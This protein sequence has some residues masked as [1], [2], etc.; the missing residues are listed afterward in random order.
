MTHEDLIAHLAQQLGWSNDTVSASLDALIA[1]LKSELDDNK[2]VTIDDFGRFLVRNYP[3]YILRD[4]ETNE[5]YLMPPALEVEFEGEVSLCFTPDDALNDSVN[6]AFSPFEPVLINEGADFPGLQEVVDQELDAN[7]QE[8][9]DADIAPQQ[10]VAEV[11]DTNMHEV[12]DEDVAPQHAVAEEMEETLQVEKAEQVVMVKDR[13]DLP[14]LRKKKKGKKSSSVW[15]PIAGGVAVALAVLFFFKGGEP[16]KSEVSGQSPSVPITEKVSMESPVAEEP[17]DVVLP[18]T[19]INAPSQEATK[20]RL[21]QGKT[22]R[23]LALELFGSR[24]FW[25]YIYLENKTQISNP[26][27]VPIGLELIV[28]DQ[29]KYGIDA[30]DPSSVLK[31]KE[32]SENILGAS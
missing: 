23:V 20:V 13:S 30:N 27:Q 4:G 1:V 21:T 15:I 25:V 32:M 9:E 10:L 12:E 31:A 8:V 2:T 19:Q 18:Q 28:P 14:P 17:V 11:M 22:L 16:V 3:E 24:E 7:L 6:S 5:R 26:N 29:A